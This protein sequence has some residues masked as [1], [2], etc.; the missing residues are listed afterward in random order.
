MLYVLIV[1]MEDVTRGEIPQTVV[2]PIK[3]FVTEEQLLEIWENRGL[4]FRVDEL[5]KHLR[6]RGLLPHN[7]MDSFR[8]KMYGM[9]KAFFCDGETRRDPRF[10]PP[11][12]LSKRL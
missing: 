12:K 4:K 6:E 11:L 10:V 3:R 2:L 9:L 5:H 1:S 8:R 7:R